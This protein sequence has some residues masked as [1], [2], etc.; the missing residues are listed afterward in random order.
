M[1]KL[2][3]TL[4]LSALIPASSIAS[5]SGR[6]LQISIAPNGL[7]FQQSDGKPFFWLADT[8]WLMAQKL[9][10]DE[11]DAYF[12]NRKAKG[13]NVVQT[14][15]FQ[16]LNDKNVYGDTA[17]VGGD[18][19][20]LNMTDGADPSDPIQYDYWDHVDYIIDTAAKHGIQIAIAPAWSHTVRR[21]PITAAQISPY[22]EIL[23]NRWKDKTN[24]IWLNG[25]S[26]KGD[27]NSDVWN[28]IGTI[29]K[30][31]AP[32]QLVT[33]H[34][35]G[36]TSSSQWYHDAK[37]L[38]FNMYVSGHR[39]YNQDIEG[40]KYG[41]DNWRYT[42]DDLAMTLR[43]PTLDGEPAYENTPQGLHSAT[44]PYWSANDVRRYA[45]WS[46]FAGAAGHTYGENSVRQVY[47][48]S[49]E[50]PASGAKG[51]YTERLEAE[52]A[53]SMVHLKSLMLSRPFFERVNDQSLVRT[54]Q[55]EQYERVIVTRGKE[56]LMA[57]TYSGR[58][59][60]VTLNKISGARV[61]A[62]WYNPRD[63]KAISIGEFRNRGERQFN[64]PG[65][66]ENG[67]DWV[68]VIDDA[69]KRFIEPGILSDR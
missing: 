65:E 19:S 51:Y 17:A 12:A 60:N 18:I 66:P 30:K 14:V 48:P 8:N 10:R 4:L 45:Y 61:K 52:G 59:F 53:K 28:A 38:D 31:N 39:R 2:I 47:L 3:A 56:F 32:N 25:G 68:L 55:G 33:F 58:N 49:D 1:R 34:P 7:N 41:E 50:R 24:L 37:W 36:R 63:G 57:Y 40:K 11:I 43:K 46:V 62:W 44:E 9:N 15:V 20:K 42:L 6:N 54:N 29:A 23:S 27:L 26:A 5:E 67:N 21:A 13:F 64:P 35:F 22:M 16:M 69:S